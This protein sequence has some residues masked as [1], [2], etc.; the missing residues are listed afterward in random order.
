MSLYNIR[1]IKF[2]YL[3]IKSLYKHYKALKNTFAIHSRCS[4]K[5]L[6]N[7]L[8]SIKKKLKKKLCQIKIVKRDKKKKHARRLP[9]TFL[10][11]FVYESAHS[12]KLFHGKF[13]YS[14]TAWRSRK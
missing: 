4:Q 7:R 1:Y 5:K 13:L 14:T 11:V 8:S 6:L 2:F 12:K 3:F 10:I 9:L